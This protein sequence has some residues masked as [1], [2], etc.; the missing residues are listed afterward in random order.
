MT[1]KH[2]D[3]LVVVGVDGSPS[4][5]AALRWA[6]GFAA[7]AGARLDVVSAWQIP[8]VFAGPA[9]I[10]PAFDVGVDYEKRLGQIVDDE[11]GP[12]RPPFMRLV[13]REGTPARVLIEAS[14]EA[15]LLVVG[16]RGH[17]GFAGMLLGSVSAKV[18]EHAPCPVLIHHG[19]VSIPEVTS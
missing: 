7:Q 9:Y 5:R 18:A 15:D 17:G 1:T 14:K 19:D 10:P 2:M 4:S 16:S 6:E 11:F 13:V 3:P 8:T 12:R